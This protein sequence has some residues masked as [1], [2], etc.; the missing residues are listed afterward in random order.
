[1]KPEQFVSKFGYNNKYLYENIKDI[2]PEERKVWDNLFDFGLI[3]YYKTMTLF[4]ISHDNK[5][6]VKVVISKINSS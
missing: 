5:T 6:L 2:T 3:K 1:M 4:R